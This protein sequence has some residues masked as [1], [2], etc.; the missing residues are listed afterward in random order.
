MTKGR[1]LELAAFFNLHC[2]AIPD[3]QTAHPSIRVP[4]AAAG[5]PRM[6]PRRPVVR[7]VC[8]APD[9]WKRRGPGRPSH[10]ACSLGS[11]GLSS[12]DLSKHGY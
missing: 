5:K 3:P 4:P 8:S 9:Q 11:L 6:L 2:L 10:A 12:G 1:P 7:P